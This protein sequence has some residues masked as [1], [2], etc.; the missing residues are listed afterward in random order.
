MPPAI[1]PG[2]SILQAIVETARA[3]FGGVDILVNNA[4]V[5]HA[6]PVEGFSPEKWDEGIAVNL[7]AAFHLIRLT[8]R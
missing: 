7:S 4:V 5:R 6:A 8:M 2:W 1:S 3:A